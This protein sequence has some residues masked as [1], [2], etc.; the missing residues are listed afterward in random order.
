V[1]FRFFE[2][3]YMSELAKEEA[4]GSLSMKSVEVSRAFSLEAFAKPDTDSLSKNSNSSEHGQ[5][6]TPGVDRPKATANQN[7]QFIYFAPIALERDSKPQVHQPERAPVSSAQVARDELRRAG[8]DPGRVTVPVAVFEP[9]E[10]A[11]NG[12]P[13]LWHANIVARMINDQ[14]F[15]LAPGAT[16]PVDHVQKPFQSGRFNVAN[17]RNRSVGDFA[18]DIVA[19]CFDQYTDYIANARRNGL[20]VATISSGVDNLGALYQEC[21]Q[22]AATQIELN[23]ESRPDLVRHI[24]GNRADQYFQIQRTHNED[25]QRRLQRFCRENEP[26]GQGVTA[27]QRT[28]FERRRLAFIQDERAR[29]ERQSTDAEKDLVGTLRSGLARELGIRSTRDAAPSPDGVGVI[30]EANLQRIHQAIQRW[31][32]TARDAAT[33]GMVIVIAA[34]NAGT[35]T[36]NILAR[37]PHV[38]SVGAADI[39]NSAANA[40]LGHVAGFSSTG[41]NGYRGLPFAGP[42]LVA[43]GHNLPLEYQVSVWGNQRTNNT[44]E[45]TSVAA[46][47]VG[48][49]VAL[50]LTQNPRL[51][52]NQVRDMLTANARPLP[53]APAINRAVGTIV[54]STPLDLLARTSALTQGDAPSSAQGAGLLNIVGAV[55]AAR[56]SARR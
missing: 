39:N 1:D 30:P 37:S 3:L 43:Q 45:G 32:N 42:T 47:L 35:N 27:Q 41:N 9:T 44:V 8:I 2:A 20:R 28:E 6:L 7:T 25:F 21:L 53:F 17:Y 48:A 34:A 26:S 4:A 10:W 29:S 16:V 31:E 18:A 38:I 36:Y 12:G 5:P 52:F 40:R 55:Q 24:L 19:D 22:E 56:D 14:R 13:D 46:P 51:S 50:M 11:S 15:G 54:P 49:T 33:D 23:P